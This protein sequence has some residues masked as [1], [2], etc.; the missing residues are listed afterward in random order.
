MSRSC[1][2]KMLYFIIWKNQY[3]TTSAAI[4]LKETH[5]M[6]ILYIHQYFTTP[7]EGGGTR[8]YEFARYLVKQGHKLTR[9]TGTEL[10]T[11]LAGVNQKKDE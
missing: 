8:S 4:Q 10:N 3:K 1:D 6:N 7:E 9:L 2:Y 11:P 5:F